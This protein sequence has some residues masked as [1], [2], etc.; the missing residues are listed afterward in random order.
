MP[1]RHA[2]NALP[3]W[4]VGSTGRWIIRATDTIGGVCALIWCLLRRLYRPPKEGRRL[5][6]RVVVEQIYFT[7][8]QALWLIIPIA[9]IIGTA[10]IAQ[11]ARVSGQYDAG[12]LMVVLVVREFG[13]MITALIVILRSA[14]SVTIELGY[15]NVLHE[16]D[17]VEAAGIDPWRVLLMPR[18][19]GITSAICSLFIVFD[20]CAILGGYLIIWMFTY[21]PVADFLNQVSKAV[22]GADIWVGIV[23]GVLF[24]VVISATSI[25]HGLK[26]HRRITDIPPATSR[27]AVESFF[28]C[29]VLNA[30]VSIMFY[31]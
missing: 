4:I 10:L 7:A 13:P 12:R 1:A 5:V 9:L 17:A 21:L 6:R 30:L 29:L 28:Y 2:R 19:F 31:L 16:L 22:T 23:K 20:L 18:M 8:I 24:G 25:H 14:T 15:M 26:T 3:V 11:F 27:A